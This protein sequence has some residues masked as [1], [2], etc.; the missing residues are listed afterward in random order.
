MTKRQ[1]IFYRILLL[2]IL[3]YFGFKVS[4]TLE[5]EP[6]SKEI[7]KKVDEVQEEID[8]ET[9]LSIRKPDFYKPNSKKTN[10]KNLGD[11]DD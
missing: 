7:Q 5:K 10:S 4:K 9:L 8:I 3:I 6:A 2:G 1:I 11:K